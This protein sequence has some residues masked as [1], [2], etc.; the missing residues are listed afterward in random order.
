MQIEGL[1]V[2][3]DDAR[4]PWRSTRYRGIQWMPLHPTEPAA[5][6]SSA[7]ASTVL[8]RMEPGCGY[9]RH[10]HLDLEEVL[11][12]RG[13]YRD[14]SGAHRAG[15]YL[16]YPKDSAHAPVA[17]GDPARPP[18]DDNPACILFAVAHGGVENSAS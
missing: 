9:P 2:K 8:I 17:L 7:R 12:L 16:R 15:S 4:L 13:G 6:G 18:G 11:I 14:E 10:V 3:L 1:D 5:S